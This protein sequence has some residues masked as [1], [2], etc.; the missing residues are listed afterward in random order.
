MD[1]LNI[2]LRFNNK[3][4]SKLSLNYGIHLGGHVRL[5]CIETS[6]MV[7][8]VRTRN[9][10]INLNS[11][12]VEL[13][14][15]LKVLEGLGFLRGVIYFI[16]STLGFRLSFKNSFNNF[17][18]HLFFPIYFNIKSVLKNLKLFLLNKQEMHL[19][20][21]KFKSHK[22]FF[23]RSGK[24]LLRKFFV[25]SK[26]SNGFVSN[27]S[28]FFSFVDNVLHE[29]IK[30]GKMFKTFREKIKNFL[31]FYPLLP[32][33]S[34]IGDNRV[35]SWIVNEFRMASVPCSSVV[36]TFSTKSLLNMYGLPGN[37]NSIDSTLFFLV[38]TIS[39]YLTGF[40]QH[41]IRFFLN[42]IKINYNF[43]VLKFDFKNIFF[44]NF[45]QV[46]ILKILN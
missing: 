40:Y 3:F 7:F 30:F 31:D 22:I 12:L 14:K 11:T 28:T 45:K 25:A 37:S 18:R 29:K 24:A 27:S 6:S 8:G 16:N 19:R 13:A 9:L 41:I 15:I 36:D 42:T 21:K 2:K 20:S 38:L 44:N 34:F 33:Y 32:H 1:S 10:V 39:N 35:N 26:W 5:L 23:I 46:G 17:N 43:L 4:S